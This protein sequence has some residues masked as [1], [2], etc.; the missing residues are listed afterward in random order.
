MRQNKSILNR[1]P[2]EQDYRPNISAPALAE[3]QQEMEA[4]SAVVL[5]SDLAQSSKVHYIDF[6]DRFVRWL[7]GE[8]TPGISKGGNGCTISSGAPKC[9]VR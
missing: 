2:V 1:H 9:N 3:V 8:F 7:S 5:R 6:A 4:Y